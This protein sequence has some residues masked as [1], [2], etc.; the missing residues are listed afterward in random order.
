M[1]KRKP[2]TNLQSLFLTVLTADGNLA[3]EALEKLE[4]EFKKYPPDFSN[5]A[6]GPEMAKRMTEGASNITIGKK[7]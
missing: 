3:K 4:A 7:H 2:R 6:F 1:N 5:I